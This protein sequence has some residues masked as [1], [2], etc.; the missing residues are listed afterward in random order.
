VLFG[1]VHTRGLSRF[2]SQK[3]FNSTHRYRFPFFG[4]IIVYSIPD[5]DT[6]DGLPQSRQVEA[7]RS[8]TARRWVLFSF[9]FLFL[10]M[11]SAL[12]AQL[13][14]RTQYQELTIPLAPHLLLRILLHRWSRPSDMGASLGPPGCTY[15]PPVAP[16]LL[17]PLRRLL[18]PR[19]HHGL[20]VIPLVAGLSSGEYHYR[21]PGRT[22]PAVVVRPVLRAFQ[23]HART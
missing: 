20:L 3:G 9:F 2:G 17:P 7:S 5:H 15:H 16:L 13:F 11:H 18:D 10:F 4:F 1:G 14:K 23:V 6:S 22:T 12:A 21:F 8:V 19:P